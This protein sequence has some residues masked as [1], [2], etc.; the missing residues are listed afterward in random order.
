[1][2]LKYTILGI[3]N[4]NPVTGY[5]LKKI[6]Q[7]SCFIYWS[8]NN[9]QIYKIL[10]ELSKERF[11]IGKVE[12]NEN[13][14]SKKIYSITD[15]G[16]KELETWLQEE[17]EIMEIRKPFLLQ[18]AWFD[19]LDQ[20]KLESKLEEYKKIIQIKILMEEDKISKRVFY[21]NRNSREELIWEL[22]YENIVNSYKY[23]LEWIKK[24]Q[25]V[26]SINDDIYENKDLSNSLKEKVFCN[27]KYS[28]DFNNSYNQNIDIKRKE[29][30]NMIYEIIKQHNK[31]Y[32]FVKEAKNRLKSEEDAL[33]FISLCMETGINRLF[34]CEDI[35]GEEF[36]DLKTKVAGLIIQKF[37]TYNVKCVIFMEK[38]NENERFK[39]FLYE[40]NKGK[41]FRIYSNFEEA[42]N[43]IIQN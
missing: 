24:V 39:E 13:S 17:S 15:L 7:E 14:P 25:N 4:F 38:Q 2:S 33:D 28:N 26:L 11:V 16:K 22:L 41:I 20:Q 3:I 1:M 8:G 30:N 21:P 19:I 35:L 36:F 43:W 23:E 12:H 27:T 31:E 34:I 32:L 10:S 6:I 29:D 9:N 42:K 37:T 40:I 18:F 5:D